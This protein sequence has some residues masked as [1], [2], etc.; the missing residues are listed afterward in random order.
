MSRPT[1]VT[2]SVAAGSVGGGW[3]TVSCGAGAVCSDRRSSPAS[4][5]AEAGRS[6]GSLA[7][8]ATIRSRAARGRSG[9][10][11][12]GSGTGLM[13]WSIAMGVPSSPTKGR[14][15]QAASKSTQQR[16]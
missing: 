13:M 5:V 3:A 7:R 10:T 15:P 1:G 8:P 2:G 16:L 6:A 14:R 12:N 4:A 11:S 9:A